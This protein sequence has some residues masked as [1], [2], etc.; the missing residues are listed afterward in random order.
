VG[1]ARRARPHRDR[2]PSAGLPR[3]DHTRGGI[4]PPRPTELGKRRRHPRR[5]GRTPRSPCT[6]PDATG[7]VGRR[8]PQDP[9]TRRRRWRPGRRM[10]RVGRCRQPAAHRPSLVAARTTGT[11]RDAGVAP[12]RRPIGDRAGHCRTGPSSA[13]RR[14]HPRQFDRPAAHRGPDGPNDRARPVRPLPLRPATTTN[15]SP[16]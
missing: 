12:R 6:A 13:P 2:L 7:R 3:R 4:A 11:R 15:R 9:A 10:L 16:D 8:W 5:R 1:S 14:P